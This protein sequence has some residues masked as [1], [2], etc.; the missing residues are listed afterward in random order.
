MF[1]FSKKYIYKWVFEKR[2]ETCCN[3]EAVKGPCLTFFTVFIHVGKKKQLQC[4]ACVVPFQLSWRL[5]CVC[6]I[7]TSTTDLVLPTCVL[8]ERG[9][10]FC[11]DVAEVENNF[12][13][14]G[15]VSFCYIS[16]PH[17]HA[18]LKWQSALCSITSFYDIVYGL[19]CCDSAKSFI[20]RS[21]TW[22]MPNW[23][24]MA[25]ESEV[26]KSR[27]N[28]HCCYTSCN[29]SCLVFVP[30]AQ[31][32]IDIL[33]AIGSFVLPTDKWS[34]RIWW[35]TEKTQKSPLWPMR[36]YKRNP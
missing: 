15:F 14:V 30:K 23:T 6:N 36:G 2:R 8:M 32:H 27:T 35:Q 34:F 17:L 18:I 5:V 1:V 21:S 33:V 25:F 24:L 29:T 16:L 10:C 20:R 3:K 31:T 4:D 22:V 12:C 19:H 13:C 7:F 9:K 11:T 26:D 28:I